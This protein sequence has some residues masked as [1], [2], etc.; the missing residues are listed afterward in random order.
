LTNQQHNVIVVL[1]IP[2]FVDIGSPWRVLPHGIHTG[3]IEDVRE[4]FAN[5]PRRRELFEGLLDACRA[6]SAAGCKQ[7]FLDGSF[8]TEKPTPGDYDVCWDPT[9]VNVNKLDPVFL[10]FRDFRKK[11]KQ[12][13]GGEFFPSSSKADGSRTFIE[14]FQTDKYTGI[15]KGIIRIQL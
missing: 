13:Y 11:Q 6:L 8:V 5:N 1:M 2:D 14:Y 12:I 3:T 15:E 4:K 7:I 9:N 10:D